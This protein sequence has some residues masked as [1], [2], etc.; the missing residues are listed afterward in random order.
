MKVETMQLKNKT[1]LTTVILAILIFLSAVI[2]NRNNSSN[3]EIVNVPIEETQQNKSIKKKLKKVIR[4]EN[5]IYDREHPDYLSER[6][7][8]NIKISK[9][10]AGDKMFLTMKL[11]TPES[12]LSAI[13]AAQKEGHDEYADTLIEFLL[14]RFPDYEIP[15]DF[16]Q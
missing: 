16:G 6:E 14:E 13:E 3:T 10:T 9:K 11:K 15:E 4:V 1:L 5:E 2:W 7:L 8:E 12:V